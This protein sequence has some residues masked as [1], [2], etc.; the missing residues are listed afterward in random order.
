MQRHRDDDDD[1]AAALERVEAELDALE[2][3][4]YA[5]W[6]HRAV[7][8]DVA[9][10]MSLLPDHH[11]LHLNMPHIEY[12]AFASAARARNVTPT[13]LARQIIAE[14]CADELGADFADLPWIMHYGFPGAP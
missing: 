4:P 10:A 7:G 8:M 2:P 6:R 14:W 12:V 5:M 9:T 11:S 13:V 1:A 3:T